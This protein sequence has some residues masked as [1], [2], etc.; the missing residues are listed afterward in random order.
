MLAITNN[1][2]WIPGTLWEYEIMT[3]NIQH[4][5]WHRKNSSREGEVLYLL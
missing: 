3:R 1:N 2:M 4:S 5:V